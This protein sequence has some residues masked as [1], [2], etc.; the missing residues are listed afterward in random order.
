MEERAD[1]N[2]GEAINAGDSVCRFEV[3]SRLSSNEDKQP[4]LPPL[5]CYLLVLN[6]A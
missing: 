1:P 6:V 5:Q 4:L 2:R 3:S